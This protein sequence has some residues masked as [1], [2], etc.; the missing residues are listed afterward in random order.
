VHLNVVAIKRDG[1]PT[2]FQPGADDS[3]GAG[4]R[5]VVVGDGENLRRIADLAA[6]KGGSR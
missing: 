6:E 4:D 5:V 1:E 2:R 3:L